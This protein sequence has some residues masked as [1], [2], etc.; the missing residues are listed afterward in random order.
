MSL[1]Q[2]LDKEAKEEWNRAL[3]LLL[4]KDGS[5]F[6]RTISDMDKEQRL[7]LLNYAR[8]FTISSILKN[9]YY[10]RTGQTL[11]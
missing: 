9:G 7:R 4:I 11:D 8:H 2:I 5:K 6:Y 3:G 10:E 1:Q